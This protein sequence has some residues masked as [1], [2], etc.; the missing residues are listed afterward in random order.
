V[1]PRKIGVLRP[2]AIGRLLAAR[3]S[4]AGRE[5]TVIA[6]EQTAVAIE[7]TGLTL[8]T[9][10]EQPETTPIA[11]RWLTAP[12]AVLFV[13]TTATD[14]PG[15]LERVPPALL[16]A[17]TIVPLLTVSITFRCSGRATRAPASWR[18]PSASRRAGRG[19][20]SP[21]SIRSA[22]RQRA[23]ATRSGLGTRRCDARP[24]VA[25]STK[26]QRR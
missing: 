12:V 24:T 26:R 8:Q 10:H 21:S 20:G 4:K 18:R 19:S 23:R 25:S 2:G 6:T 7:L 3:S 22:A 17:S 11:R 15:A 1:T 9:P 16:A 13:T 5:V 14:L